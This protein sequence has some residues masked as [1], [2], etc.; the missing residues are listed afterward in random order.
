MSKSTPA[1]NR[2]HWLF[3]EFQDF[4]WSDEDEIEAYDKNANVNPALERKRL[5]ELGV[6]ENHSLIDFGCGTGALAL[7]A[8]RLCQ[9]VI[10]VDVSTAMLAYMKRK[11]E[12][13]VPRHSVNDG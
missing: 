4:G 5:L 8:A 7:E 6:S 1:T 13:L 11:A 9:K 10:A 3:D 2:P 12:R